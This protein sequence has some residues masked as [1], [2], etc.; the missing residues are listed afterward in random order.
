M[1]QKC[2]FKSSVWKVFE[3]FVDE[4]LRIHYVKEI[5]KKIN[6]APTS[7]KKHIID[8]ENGEMVIK[9]KGDIFSGYVSNRDNSNFLFYKKMFNLMKLKESKLIDYLVENLYPKTIVLYGSYARGEDIE[10]SDIDLLIISKN[11]KSLDLD[12]FEK[13]LK[14][15]IHVINETNLRKLNENLQLEIINGIILYGYLKNE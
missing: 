11:D 13:I 1:E 10:E 6:L 9:K 15:K 8:L 2:I 5:S 4:P 3:I 7:V 12:K 14:R